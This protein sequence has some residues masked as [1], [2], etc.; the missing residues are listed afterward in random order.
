MAVDLVFDELKRI[1]SGIESF[2]SD[3]DKLKV[4]QQRILDNPDTR[5]QEIQAKEL[6]DINKNFNDLHQQLKSDIIAINQRQ[7]FVPSLHLAQVLFH[8]RRISLMGSYFTNSKNNFERKC[9]EQML[10][11]ERIINP[12]ALNEEDIPQIGQP[13]FAELLNRGGRRGQAQRVKTAEEIRHGGLKRL[14]R[15]VYEI[16]QSIA[17]CSG[18]IEEQEVGIMEIEQK[19][20]EVHENSKEAEGQVEITVVKTKARKRR[21]WWCC[22]ISSKS[23]VL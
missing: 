21:H 4:I 7:D 1:K 11:I 3:L 2:E 23:L 10:R 14:E 19:G 18:M 17:V 16:D 9:D 6:I 5:L 8:K 22:G 20:A 13:L 12:Y 15:T